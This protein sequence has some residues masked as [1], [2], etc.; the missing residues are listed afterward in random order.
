M[1]IYRCDR[2][3]REVEHPFIVRYPVSY[4]VKT[5]SEFLGDWMM[6]P[7]DSCREEF[8]RWLRKG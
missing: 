8:F 7:C 1:K 4:K 5:G 2:C 3:G 6:E